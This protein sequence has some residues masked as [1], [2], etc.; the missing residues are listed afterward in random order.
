MVSQAIKCHKTIFSMGAALLESEV[1]IPHSG[2]HVTLSFVNR[3]SLH[4]MCPVSV[5][6]EKS[7][8][9]LYTK[10]S[11][12]NLLI[13]SWKVNLLWKSFAA[14]KNEILHMFM[15]CPTDHFCCIFTGERACLRD[16]KPGTSYWYTM[17]LAYGVLF[18]VYRWQ[19][20]SYKVFHWWQHSVHCHLQSQTH[21]YWH[22][23]PPLMFPKL[24]VMRCVRVV[25]E[26]QQ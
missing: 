4:S 22:V 16:L 15:F 6:I 18:S 26:P 25:I 9:V 2:R 23:G 11:V 20:P 17:S 24:H 5:I 3:S 21:G 1:H 8:N 13:H 19:N 7:V 10:I 12:T 14:I